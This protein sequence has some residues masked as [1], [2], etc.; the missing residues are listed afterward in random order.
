V[1]T[2]LATYNKVIQAMDK[3]I[4]FSKKAY[5]RLLKIRE[6]NAGMLMT[7]EEE[8]V[9]EVMVRLWYSRFWMRYS[10]F[11]MRYTNFKIPRL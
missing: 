6:E 4:E 8:I 3:A 11:W 7:A 2:S 10:R 1:L 9:D 5:E